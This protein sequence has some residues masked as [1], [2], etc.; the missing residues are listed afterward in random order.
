V[1]SLR[2]NSTIGMRM[3]ALFQVLLPPS[4]QGGRKTAKGAS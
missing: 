2:L 3:P 1:Q 4:S